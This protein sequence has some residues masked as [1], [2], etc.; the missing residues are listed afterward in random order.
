MLEMEETA[1]TLRLSLLVAPRSSKNAVAGVHAQALKVKLTAPPVDGK[2]NQAALRFLSKTLG[3]PRSDLELVS[4]QTSRRKRIQI[5]FTDDKEGR[6]ELRRV[7]ELLV[8]Y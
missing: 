8:A 6:Q 2:A 4:G 7:K 3:V 5:R 1:T